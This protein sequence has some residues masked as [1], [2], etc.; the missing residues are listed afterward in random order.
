MTEHTI[1][2]LDLLER[3]T[4]PLGNISSTLEYLLDKGAEIDPETLHAGLRLVQANAEDAYNFLLREA[5]RLERRDEPRTPEQ[6][7]QLAALM[8]YR[9]ESLDEPVLEH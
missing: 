4:L 5:G 6:L 7:R 3:V 8:S 2:R 9:E 1:N